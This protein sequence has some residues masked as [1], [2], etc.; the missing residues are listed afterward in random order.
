MCPYSVGPDL[1][2][3]VRRSVSWALM[4][5]GLEEACCRH[6]Y[7]RDMFVEVQRLNGRGHTLGD[8]A[9][10]QE[11]TMQAAITALMSALRDSE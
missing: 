11:A 2:T 6:R 10:V 3:D 8:A 7:P 4:D 1:L 5:A 9:H